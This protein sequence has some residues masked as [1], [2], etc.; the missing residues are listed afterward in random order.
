MCPKQAREPARRDHRSQPD[1]VLDEKT[2]EALVREGQEL[3]RTF[4]ARTAG[5]RVITADDMKTRSR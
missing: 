1:H 5:M 2:F 4:D 3:R